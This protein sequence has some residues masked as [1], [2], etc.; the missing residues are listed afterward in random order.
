MISIY[1][2]LAKPQRH[3]ALFYKRKP[4]VESLVIRSIRKKEKNSAERQI[5]GKAEG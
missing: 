2:F 1:A 5:I 3:C 4:S